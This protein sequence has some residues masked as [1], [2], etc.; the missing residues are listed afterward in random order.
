MKYK[1]LG[2]TVSFNNIFLNNFRINLD[3]FDLKK[4]RKKD[5]H[6]CD[7]KSGKSKYIERRDHLILTCMVRNLEGKNIESNYMYF[8]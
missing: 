6:E 2:D 5:G 4:K 1:R 3:Q 7:Y 8:K